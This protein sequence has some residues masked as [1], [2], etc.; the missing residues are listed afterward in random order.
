MKTSEPL[1][2]LFVP[3]HLPLIYHELTASKI[4]MLPYVNIPFHT[5]CFPSQK[6]FS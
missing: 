5:L 2:L 1:N 3:Y 6:V 4:Y